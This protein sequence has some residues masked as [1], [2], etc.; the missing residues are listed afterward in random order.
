MKRTHFLC[1]SIIIVLLASP[2]F[3]QRTTSARKPSSTPTSRASSDHQ[4]RTLEISSKRERVTQ[5]K[6]S[7]VRIVAK[8]GSQPSNGTGFVVRK[9]GLI[10]TASHVVRQIKTDANGRQTAIDA[11]PIEVQFNDGTKPLAAKIHM[12][13]IDFTKPETVE[14]VFQDIC[15]LRV[16]PTNSVVPVALGSFSDITE[17]DDIYLCGYPLGI[18]QPVVAFGVLST[19]V[20]DSVTNQLADRKITWFREIAWLD[21]TMN[22]GNSGGPILLIGKEPKD[23]KV[24]GVA[25]FGL[26]PLDKRLGALIQALETGGVD[27]GLGVVSFIRLFTLTKESLLSSSVGVSACVWIDYLKNKI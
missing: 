16:N 13:S 7:M 9:D 27:I 18:E 3:G 25:S 23:D 26:T 11:Y 24:I 5:I 19:K 4:A 6:K 20:P 17:G 21:I 14:P 12:T 1:V 15:L 8:F 22:R 10:A 2:L